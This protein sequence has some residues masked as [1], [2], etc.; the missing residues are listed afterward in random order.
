MS[1]RAHAIAGPELQVSPRQLNV[2]R[3]TGYARRAVLPARYVVARN[4]GCASRIGSWAGKRTACGV[5]GCTWEWGMHHG[6]R[7]VGHGNECLARCAAAYLDQG[8]CGS[9][10]S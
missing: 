9:S 3:T 4:A 1:A 7:D 2:M 8:D 5:A 10:C 6:L